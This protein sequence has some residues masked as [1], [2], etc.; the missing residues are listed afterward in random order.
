[1]HMMGYLEVVGFQQ[2]RQNAKRIGGLYPN[3]KDIGIKKK[4]EIQKF[5]DPN[6]AIYLE[7]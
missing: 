1:M 7:S 6:I 4:F 3:N 5:Q 2:D